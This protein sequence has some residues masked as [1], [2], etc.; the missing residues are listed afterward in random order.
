MRVL[1]VNY[2]FKPQC[3][4]AGIATYNLAKELYKQGVD[5]DLM[6]GWDYKFG[7]PDK[8]QGVQQNIISIKKKSIH[9]SSPLGILQF[10]FR[11]VFLINHLTR[12]NKY[13][14]IMFYFSIP[15]GVLKYGIH[16]RVPYV[17]SL[18]GIDVPSPRKDKYMWLRNMLESLNGRIIRNASSVTALSTEL[19]AWFNSVYSNVPVNIIPNGIT[20][21]NY[22]VKREYHTEVV[23]FVTV[24][25]LIDCKNIE[26]S[27]YA[28]KEVH[29]IYPSI[30]L[31]IIGDGYLREH[32]QSVIDCE[33][34]NDYVSLLGYIESE[35]I[36]SMMRD[37]DVF[38]LLTVADSFGQAFIEAMACGLPVICAD[39]G[40]P[41]DIVIDGKTGIM[42]KANQKE[43]VV[44][45]IEKYIENPELAHIHGVNGYNRVKSMYT[46]ERVA[47][48]HIELF[49]EICQRT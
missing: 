32:L 35:S 6:F 1:L 31:D 47:K 9:E 15:T 28:M 18:R 46:I 45:A 10:V 7:V 34:M 21:D 11:G 12:Q 42:T 22:T 5:V 39:V 19:Q 43:S 16:G 25:R 14:I 41:K 26:L 48:A 37:Y 30:R 36:A 13:D 40:G 2:E 24:S 44:E 8:I 20:L 23:R 49:K 38:I 4:G 27:M 17:C 3:G 33:N 29:D